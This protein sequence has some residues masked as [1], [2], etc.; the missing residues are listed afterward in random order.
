VGFCG[1]SGVTPVMSI[2][3][4]LLASSARPVR[5]LYAN[6]DL[7]SVIFLDELESLR[8]SHPDQLD[9]RHHLD[10]ERGFVDATV[11]S[12]FVAGDLDADFYICGPG[13]FMD[14]VEETLVEIGVDADRIS[15]ERFI[16][17]GQP[18]PARPGGPAGTEA[19][20]SP[21][22]VPDTVTVILKGKR[23]AIA[24]QPGDTVLETARR[25][26]L[27]APFSCESGNCATCMAL[28]CEGSA[29]MRVNNALTPD[30]VAEGWV[31]TCQAL[32]QG[33][34]LTVEYESF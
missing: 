3:K 2:T 11:I 9:V 15:V 22:E 13:P 21:D 34:T 6:R 10:D 19:V 30:E 29:T 7:G 5:L 25:G 8:A 28:V 4:S 23:N 26:G 33:S 31:L 18:T 14:L 1:G 16:N 32:P 17:A 27:Q 12:D 20:P 24:Y